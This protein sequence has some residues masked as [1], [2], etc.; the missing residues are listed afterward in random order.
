LQLISAQ[1]GVECEHGRFE[2]KPLHLRP[3]VWEPLR[4]LDNALDPLR[5]CDLPIDVADKKGFGFRASLESFNAHRST[6][7]IH[8]FKA[9]YRFTPSLMHGRRL[10]IGKPFVLHSYRQR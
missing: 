5:N 9:L 2:R 4:L 7:K 8:R 1:N 6:P 10:G 3:L